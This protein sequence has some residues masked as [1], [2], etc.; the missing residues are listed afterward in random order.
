VRTLVSIVSLAFCLNAFAGQRPDR[1]DVPLRDWPVSFNHV[2]GAES[3]GIARAESAA[4]SPSEF[5]PVTP[6]RLVDT[7]LGGYSGGAF[8]AAEARSY[9]VPNGPCGVPAASAYSLNF[10]IVGYT[11][12]GSLRAFPTGTTLP[13]I[14][15]L[16]FGD[17]LPIANGAI[18]QASATG[19][20]DVFVTGATN[21]IIDIN[22]YFTASASVP[23]TVVLN[24]PGSTPLTVPAG[25]GHLLVEAWGGGGSGALGAAPPFGS[26]GGGAYVRAFVPVTPG[27]ALTLIVGSGGDLAASPNGTATT[28]QKDLVPVLTA[29][30]GTGGTI[31]TFGIGG[32]GTVAAGVVV[33]QNTPGATLTAGTGPGAGGGPG[34]VGQAGLI[35]VS[36]VQ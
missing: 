3:S 17:G 1:D 27:S 5:V 23:K 6:C 8:T 28:I 20:I 26:G 35:V 34:V 10:S 14:S 13:L 9:V 15:I 33:I 32:V 19:S 4:I 21:V 30:G 25:V 36:F 16:N 11:G 7:R 24:A 2:T 22:G 12:R 18:V 31:A 29:G